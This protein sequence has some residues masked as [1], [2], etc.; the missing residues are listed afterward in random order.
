MNSESGG[1]EGD[2]VEGWFHNARDCYR[3]FA[4]EEPA[5]E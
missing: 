1:A 4:I 2:E 3:S 5:A